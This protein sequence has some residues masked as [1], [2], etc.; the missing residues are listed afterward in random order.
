M[1]H[2]NEPKKYKSTDAQRR[3]SRKYYYKKKVEKENLINEKNK[4][5]N[6]NDTSSD[7]IGIGDTENI[8]LNNIHQDTNNDFGIDADGQQDIYQFDE[9]TNDKTYIINDSN[10]SNIVNNDEQTIT[11]NIDNNQLK[12]V[13]SIFV[14]G[15]VYFRIYN[16]SDSNTIVQQLEQKEEYLRIIDRIT[17]KL[18]LIIEKYSYLQKIYNNIEDFFFIIDIVLLTS[19]VE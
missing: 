3:A 14:L 10:Y 2:E 18:K 11:V 1:S 13:L 15:Y 8:S 19:V 17:N 6:S 7:S 12:S 4:K 5:L 9:L 16:F